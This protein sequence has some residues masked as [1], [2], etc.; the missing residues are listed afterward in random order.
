MKR[1]I[2]VLMVLLVLLSTSMASAE[3]NVVPSQVFSTSGKP[4]SYWVNSY[5]NIDECIM[6]LIAEALLNETFTYE[7]IDILKFAMDND[8]VYV[9]YGENTLVSCILFGSQKQLGLIYS[10][11]ENMVVV[12]VDY[13]HCNTE[14]DIENIM[15]TIRDAGLKV[16]HIYD[17]E[18]VRKIYDAAVS[19]LGL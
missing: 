17:S 16:Y 13:H 3:Q 12:D 6:N 1:V 5:P 19:V 8:Y 4:L 10:P 2:A 7:M 18:S 11:G 14:A 15:A 9:L